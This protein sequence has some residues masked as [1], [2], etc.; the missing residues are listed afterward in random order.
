MRPDAPH[1]PSVELGEEFADVGPLV[2]MAPTTQL[3]IELI[4]QLLSSYWGAPA[5]KLAHLILETADRFLPRV[6]VERSRRGHPTQLTVAQLSSSP[7]LDLIAQEFKPETDVH[8]PGLLRIQ[9][10]S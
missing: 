6:G 8:D 10:H 7:A 1:D 2:V 4:Y 3:R 9:L 5:G